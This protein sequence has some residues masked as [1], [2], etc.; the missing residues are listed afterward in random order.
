MQN[1]LIAGSS[2]SPS[3]FM[4]K[5]WTFF[6]KLTLVFFFIIG[7]GELVLWFTALQTVEHFDSHDDIQLVVSR[8][9]E[10][11]E[12]IQQEPYSKYRNII[13]NK[14]D[15]SNFHTSDKTENIVKLPNVGRCDHTYLYHIINNY[16][17]LSNITVF[18]PGSI[19]MDHKRNKSKRLL[20]EI[21][22]R[23][24]NVF[25]GNK[26]GNVKDSF[27]NFQ[28]EEWKASDENNAKINPENK[29]ELA[30]VRPFGKWYDTKF[31]DE[32]KVEYVSYYGIFSV[33]KNE[34]LQN[35]KSY[36]EDLIQ[37]LENSSNPE[38]GHYFERSWNA[39]FHPMIETDFIEGLRQM[40]IP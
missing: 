11:L 1:G 39:V 19:N 27:Y 33:S 38:V 10:D 23:E 7:C 26:Y 12:W 8:F 13:Y 28:M 31:N 6:L 14:S 29:L 22:S 18:L 3:N 40:S 5:R 25:I 4:Q 21:E 37:E 9:N 24:K 16:D 2:R 17:N 20:D 30:S 35:S 15:N 32:R 34:I 36:Y